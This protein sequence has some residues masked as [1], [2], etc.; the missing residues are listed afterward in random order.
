MRTGTAA[1]TSPDR[2]AD[3]PVADLPVADLP[4]ADLLA[5]DLARRALRPSLRSALIL[6]V[7]ER[8]DFGFVENPGPGE[9]AAFPAIVQ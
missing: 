4:V 9:E 5:A 2:L 1:A 3:L 8:R 7:G 6:G